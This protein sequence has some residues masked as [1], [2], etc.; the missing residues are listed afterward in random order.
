[1]GNMCCA[2]LGGPCDRQMDNMEEGG[3][4]GK[5][6][7]R[8]FAAQQTVT[9]SQSESTSQFMKK[10][11][12]IQIIFSATNSWMGDCGASGYWQLM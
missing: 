5:E 11:H 1:M 2:A 10:K 3:G 9:S 8:L 4:G 6:L 12:P 7:N